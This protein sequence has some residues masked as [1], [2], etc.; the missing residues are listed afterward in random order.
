M[1]TNIL[2]GWYLSLLFPPG[3]APGFHLQIHSPLTSGKTLEDFFYFRYIV[4]KL[5]ALITIQYTKQ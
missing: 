2:G 1:L 4:L 3:S 5:Q